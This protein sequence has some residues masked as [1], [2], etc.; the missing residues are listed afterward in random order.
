[1]LSHTIV[2]LYLQIKCTHDSKNEFVR[3][4]DEN[5]R[6][7][8]LTIF[9]RVGRVNELFGRKVVLAACRY[10]GLAR[11]HLGAQV[12]PRTVATTS[13]GLPA[14]GEAAVPSR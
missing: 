13:K 5:L 4:L 12:L 7:R 6:V 3:G 11:G 1:M 9:A 10:P 8:M 14:S 2:T